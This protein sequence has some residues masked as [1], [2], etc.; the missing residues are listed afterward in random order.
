LLTLFVYES[1]LS[2]APLIE[3]VTQ[4]ADSVGNDA[5]LRQQKAIMGRPDSRPGLSD[6]RCPSLVVCGR[7]DALTPVELNAEIVGLI[8]GASLVVIDDRGHL[9]TMGPS[10][11]SQR[12]AQD[13]D[14]RLMAIWSRRWRFW[15]N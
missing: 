13:V 12:G 15:Q 1:R 14:G 2:D 6:I 11:R 10:G 3:D 9:A 5:F 7:Q 8:P 4:M